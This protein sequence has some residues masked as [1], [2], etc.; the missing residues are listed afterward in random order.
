MDDL[1]DKPFLGGSE[2]EVYERLRGALATAH[3]LRHGA[4]LEF[5]VAPLETGTGY[6]MHRISAR[7]S[8]AVYPFVDGG[9]GL[10]PK[11]L[12]PDARQ[13][14]SQ[15][16]DRL[17]SVSPA[18]APLARR[19]PVEVPLRAD[20]ERALEQLNKEWSGGPFA[21][22]TRAL[23]AVHAPRVRE[24]LDT[25]HRLRASVESHAGEPVVTHG[26]PHRRNLIRAA[27][28]YLLVDWDT[29]GLAAP[30]RDLWMLGDASGDRDA[31]DLYRV[32]WRLDDI[33]SCVT[34]LRSVHGNDEDSEKA[35]HGLRNSLEAEPFTRD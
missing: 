21:E 8:L 26:E 12:D 20:L 27:D 13:A 23:L 16:L 34:L 11:L 19:V 17:H 29:V 32:R 24:M 9:R 4:Q 5:V 6:P 1:D 7:F 2:E 30:E 22:P 18:D 14:V 28:G 15:M 35:L 25:Y 10:A 31:I 33:S 3:S